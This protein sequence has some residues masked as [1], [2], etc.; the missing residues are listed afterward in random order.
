[1]N[2]TQLSKRLENVSYFVPLNSRLADI[3]SDHAY[4]PVALML[5]KKITFAVAGEVVRGPFE[6]A[7]KQVRKNGLTEQVVVR[8]AD[9][10]EA[11]T[12][13]DKIDVVTICGMGGALICRILTDGWNKQRING[14]ERLILQPNVGEH[15]V[16]RWLAEKKYTIMQECIIEEKNKRYEI[17]VAE[18]L[19]HSV[20][21]SEM[22]LLFGPELMKDKSL[23][24]KKK[25]Q[26]ELKQ[27][28]SI[29]KS[30]DEAKGDFTIKKQ[31]IDQ[32]IKQISEVLM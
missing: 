9:G 16:R 21:Y 23:A 3:G 14:S 2:E 4:L 30:L 12:E 11:I 31:K 29:V 25:W 7:Q 1:M 19:G 32:E 20:H 27:R 13:E 17:I 22:E 15:L 18:K 10:L 5:Q 28:Q 8:L 6:L 26:S 24:F